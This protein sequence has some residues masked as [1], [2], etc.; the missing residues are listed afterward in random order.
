MNSIQLRGTQA[1]TEVAES[2]RQIF[3][4]Q[5]DNFKKTI[6]Q[7]VETDNTKIYSANDLI[8]L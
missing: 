7:Y 5:V 6:I 1:Q 4:S 8:A 3:V 2:I